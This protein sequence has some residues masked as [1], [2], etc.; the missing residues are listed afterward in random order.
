MRRGIHAKFVA[1]K[2]KGVPSSQVYERE[3]R[4]KYTHLGKRRNFLKY[5]YRAADL[6]EA[7]E[8]K[9]QVKGHVRWFDRAW[10]SERKKVY[11]ELIE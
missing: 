3:V 4:S 6:L 11:G 9:Q 10:K 2:Q 8:I 7:S 5:A 1:A